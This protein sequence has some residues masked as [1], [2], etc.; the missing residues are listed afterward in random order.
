M[1][2]EEPKYKITLHKKEKK[3]WNKPPE[4]ALHNNLDRKG[5]NMCLFRKSKEDRWAKY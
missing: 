1:R 3:W 4:R 5:L 2:L